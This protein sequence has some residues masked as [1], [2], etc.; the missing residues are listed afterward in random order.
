MVNRPAAVEAHAYN[1]KKYEDETTVILDNRVKI[2]GRMLQTLEPN[3]RNQVE[4]RFLDWKNYINETKITQW[5]L[6]A[7]IDHGII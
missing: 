6:H 1:R 5:N 4:A 7:H 3:I 2:I